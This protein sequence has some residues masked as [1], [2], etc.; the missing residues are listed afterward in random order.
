MMYAVSYTHLHIWFGKEVTHLHLAIDDA[1]G[2]IIGAY[3]DT[4]ETLHA[5]YQITYQ[6]LTTYGI[7]AKFLDVYKR[8][9]LY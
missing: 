8:Q 9:V 4:Q 7:P 2:K 1:T 6:I 5:Y 3:F